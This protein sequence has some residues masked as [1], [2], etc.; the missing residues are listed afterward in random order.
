MI[1]M[2]GRAELVG[3]L[4]LHHERE[5]YFNE[6]HQLLLQAIA[7]QAAIAVENAQLYGDVER[8]KKKL[9]VVLKNAADAILLFDEDGCLSLFNPAAERLFKNDA[10]RL[11]LPL[12]RGCG[13]DV[14]IDSLEETFST[15]RPSVREIKWT[16]QRVLVALLTPIDQGGCVA[17][18]HDVS[19]FKEL[20]RIKDEFIS[21]ASH[22]LKNPI[23]TILGF[24]QIISQAGPLNETQLDFANHI[25]SAA[26]NMNELVQDL[27][28]LAKVDANMEL[29][30]EI[31]DLNALAAEIADQFEPQASAKNQTLTLEKSKNQP[32][33]QGD[34]LQLKQA[35]RN[36]VGN[37]IKYT[38]THG[39]VKLSVFMDQ[40]NALIHVKDTGYGIPANDL[41]HI[42]DRFYR[43]HNE[44]VKGIE[45][46]GLGLAIVK[47]IIERHGGQTSVESKLGEGSC[48]IMT[49]PLSNK[50]KIRNEEFDFV[51]SEKNI[52]GQ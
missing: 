50:T 22:D 52:C 42:F 37:A 8:E 6:D 33:I 3:L 38:P 49:L 45:G 46:N 40:Q 29:K 19:H 4:V 15:G 16:D 35:L 23:T 18:L 17:L 24:S 14:L 30:R 9:S 11:G 25:Q 10:I 34:P 47:S 32:K 1:P 5:K 2:F 39:M 43:V 12:A 21:T 41:P 31:V 44:L 26:N 7:S 51:E 27:L 28:E 36:L 20:E 48:F 13:C